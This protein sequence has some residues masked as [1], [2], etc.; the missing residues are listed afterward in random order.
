MINLHSDPV[1]TNPDI[2][3]GED[4]LQSSTK[5]TPSSLEGV[6]GVGVLLV[7]VISRNGHSTKQ[8]A[9]VEFNCKVESEVL[10]RLEELEIYLCD[11][12]HC[13][14]ALP[15]PANNRMIPAVKIFIFCW[16]CCVDVLAA[17]KTKLDSDNWY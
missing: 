6:V 15:D 16:R 7:V 14:V 11:D 12:L 5:Q 4:L 9:Q 17:V 1:R 8:S 3:V 13:G 2:R 10:M